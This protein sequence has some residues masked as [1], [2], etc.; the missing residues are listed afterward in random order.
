VIG[1]LDLLKIYFAP[2]FMSCSDMLLL[3][4]LCGGTWEYIQKKKN[5]GWWFGLFIIP[6]VGSQFIFNGKTNPQANFFFFYM[7]HFI[8][9]LVFSA[10]CTDTHS[11]ARYYLVILSVLADDICLIIFISITRSLFG[12][13]YIDTGPFPI[14]ILSYF[15]LLA[16]K[17]GVTVLIKKQTRE[18]IYG[19]ESVYQALIIMLPAMP[20]FFLRS[21]AYF[22]RLNPLEVPLVIHYIDILCGVCALIN[23]IMSE[24]LSYQ[25]RQNEL[26]RMENLI[27]KQHDNYLNS[28]NSVEAVNRKY[29]DLRHI[30]RGIDSMQSMQDIKLFIKTVEGEIMDYE[31]ICNTGNKTLDIILSER[32]RESKG[33]GIQ[34]HVH[35]DGQGWDSIKDADIATIFGNALD[36]AIESTE[37]SDDNAMRLIDV[38][39]GRLNDMLIA[40]FENPF[41]H[42]L[43]KK[44]TKLISTK[45]DKQNHGYGLQS[46]ELTVKKYSG[47]MDIKTDNGTFTLTVIIPVELSQA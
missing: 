12:I 21:Y 13:D 3:F 2:L 32:M 15:L 44:Q 40:R 45:D 39:T 41:N 27:N 1:L 11:S 17:I 29:H 30:L 42:V 47:E 31:L 43:E 33:K 37:S 4:Y 46:I 14:I 38:R 10:K 18:Q 36:N 19:I 34:M 28:L 26:L 24:R 16:M 7:A 6:M 22:F 25:I 5:W 35:A 9:L 20:Y 8:L 23:M